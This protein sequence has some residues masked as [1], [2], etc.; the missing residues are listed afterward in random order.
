M[1]VVRRE[2][3]ILPLQPATP[4]LAVA[5]EQSL[6]PLTHIVFLSVIGLQTSRSDRG[7]QP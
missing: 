4:Q 1:T 5:A 2:R 7:W 3:K 6:R